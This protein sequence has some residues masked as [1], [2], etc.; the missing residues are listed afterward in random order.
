MTIYTTLNR[1]RE[2][3]PCHDG[4]TK[5]LAYLGKTQADDAPLDLL[6]ILKSNG[7]ADCLWAFQC[8]DD[9]ES[10]YRHI[11]ADFAESV[12]HI[13]ETDYPNDNRPRLAIQAARDYADGKISV[14]ALVAAGD[15]AVWD[16]AV[17]A[18]AR[19]ARPA[20]WA[21]ARAAVWAAEDATWAARAAV[22]AARAVAGAAE[23]AK[24]YSIIEK[25]LS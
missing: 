11:A 13:Y 10:I 3:N 2:N 6:T 22:A 9:N 25:W 24:Q 21:A 5:L 1:I 8:T 17:W 16:A 19:A 12:L 15:A 20:T 4:W 14:T 23:T 7:V 18:A